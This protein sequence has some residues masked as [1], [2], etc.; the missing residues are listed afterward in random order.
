M[1]DKI[2]M[3]DSGTTNLNFEPKGIGQSIEE[4]FSQDK[5]S[6]KRFFTLEGKSPFQFDIYG[7]PINWVR[8]E[9]NIT[10]DRGKTVF[11]QQNVKRPDFW[12]SLALKV[13]AS[14]YF[15]GDQEK[16]EREDS[17][18]KLIGRVSRYVQR[19]A[20]KQKYFD[21]QE[22]R[23][24]KE[25]ID[26]ICINQ[27]AAFNSPVWFN[28]G[29]QE[30]DQNAGGV[31]DFIWDS[32]KKEVIKSKKTMDRP[33]CSA[34][35]IQSVED[36][37]DSIL[38]LQVSE[39]MLFKAGSGTGTNRSTL[40]S[41]KEKLTGG[42]QASGPLSFMKGYDAYA[43]IIKSGGKTRRAAKMEILNVDHTDIIEFIES[44]QK[45][46]KKA[47]ALIEQGY[48]GGM[49]GEAYGSVAFQNCN[50]SVRISDKFME[51][52]KN[53]GNWETKFVKTG[54]KCE[55]FKANKILDKIAEG[56]WICGDPGIQCDDII[57]KYHTC[58]NSGRINASN[59]CSEYMF[60][61]DSS[62][63]LASINLMKFRKDDGFRVGPF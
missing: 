54:E 38:A 36:D 59:P 25:E 16:N 1:D 48:N 20:L 28:T 43:G 57:N 55:S 31:A 24:L 53:D 32:E 14:K 29:I 63:N 49:N 61:D 50:M 8:E 18:E 44:K 46:E 5:M 19:Q 39:A 9:V 13:V 37:M 15:W 11:T 22:S 45:E 40:R 41:S 35:F 12:S 3:Y 56:T 30:Y 60:L 27:L 2:E 47:W 17:V 21:E 23:I 10:D 52:V 34:C 51:A 4:K 58:K 7:N 33:Q 62:C 6:F 42:G 26:S